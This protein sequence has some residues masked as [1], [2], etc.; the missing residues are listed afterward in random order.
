[1]PRRLHRP[2]IVGNMTP[3]SRLSNVSYIEGSRGAEMMSLPGRADHLSNIYPSKGVSVVLWAEQELLALRRDDT[4]TVPEYTGDIWWFVLDVNGLSRAVTADT[5][6]FDRP[7]EQTFPF[8]MVIPRK[9]E[10][11]ELAEGVVALKR[12]KTLRGRDREREPP[13]PLADAA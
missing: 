10:V 5:L 11:S 7:F 2:H 1:M 13:P 9:L 3:K 4:I 8:R 6:I 12:L